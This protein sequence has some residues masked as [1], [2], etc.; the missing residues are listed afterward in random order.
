[1]KTKDAILVYSIFFGIIFWILAAFLDS[2]L[3]LQGTFTDLLYKNVPEHEILMRFAVMTFFIFF[4]SALTRSLEKRRRTEQALERSTEQYRMLFES[5]LNG[6]ALHEIIVDENGKPVDYVFLEANPIFEQI[7][8][9]KT[10]EI[11][12]KRVL[13][14]LPG[15]E[16]YW[17]ENFGNV[18][19]TRKP[20]QFE[21]YYKDLE[22]YLEVFAFSPKEKQFATIIL[23]ITERKQNAEE[24]AKLEAQLQ[25]AQKMETIGTLAGG[26]AHDFNNILAPI[27]GYTDMALED[28]PKN[29]PVREHLAHV[30]KAAKRARDLVR[31][32]MT[33]SRQV[34]SNRSSVRIQTIIKETVKL[35]RSSL[36]T[37]IKIEQHIDPMCG[38]ILGDA[39]QVQQVLMNLC[40]NSYQAI[41]NNNGTLTIIL[42]STD[43]DAKQVSALP[44]LALGTY[45]L[46]KIIDTGP[47]MDKA[48]I[49]RIF[50][51]FY[52][53]KEVGKGTG[54]G[55]SIVHGIV[56]KHD[57][58]ISAESVPGK[59]TTMNVYLPIAELGVDE[60]KKLEKET[61]K[62]EERILFI[63]DDKEI[64]I[65][66]K[67]MMERLG[68]SVTI[69]TE[70]P[71]ALEN[72]RNNPNA[73]DIVIADQIMP[74][75]T[76]TQLGVEIK[77]IRPEL[78]VIL[79]TGY[80][81]AITTDEAKDLGIRE[82]VLKPIVASELSEVIQRA[83]KSS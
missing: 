25:Q 20:I 70:S 38:T 61:L 9:I 14:V 16:S 8:G 56:R 77:K 55:L 67:E 33:F 30:V 15:T 74:T 65:L 31:Q 34:E 42:E 45:A 69:E 18:A 26:I 46:L 13:E 58:V 5:M 83:V 71:K 64:A 48:T 51:P 2:V 76:G 52:T 36:P 82:Y 12:G 47:G 80:S 53:T 81:E 39:T 59:G 32:I 54:L 41:G 28:I 7:T 37:T 6:I 73:F 3:F 22:K 27:I 43:V 66:V 68:Y 11:V 19:L 17:I 35:L 4:G 1:M 72:F 57:G 23:D 79:I 10:K 50:E 62:G 44:G 75:L 29:S 21:N 24:K 40:T 60:L 78:P 63:D 49:D